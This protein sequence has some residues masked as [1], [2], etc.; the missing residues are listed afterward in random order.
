MKT[1][2]PK[3]AVERK[4]KLGHVEVISSPL[5]K[6][7]CENFEDKEY[8]KNVSKERWE[9]L[10][11]GGK[12]LKIIFSSGSAFK[13]IESIQPPHK[14]IAFVKSALL[15]L[16]HYA[17]AKIDKKSP[18]PFAIRDLMKDSALF[19]STAFPLRHVEVPGKN[20]FH[21]IREIIFESIKDKGLNNSIDG[22][23]M[24]TLKW[25]VYEKWD[26]NSTKSLEEFGCPHCGETEATLAFNEEKGNCP[27]CNNEIF[28]TDLFGLHFAMQDDYAPDQVASDY[29][30]VCE[31]LMI[32]SPIRYFW[33]NNKE[34]LDESLMIKSGALSLRATLSKLKAPI[35]RFFKYAKDAGH[36]VALIGYER[37]GAFFDHFDLIAQDAPEGS[38]FIPDNDYIKQEIQH[39][40]SLGKYGEYTNYGAKVFIKIDKYH[41]L[42][43]NI[44]TGEQYEGILDP[45]QN[46]LIALNKIIATLPKI[47]NN[48]YEGALLPVELVSGIAS[49]STYPSA[50]ALELFSEFSKNKR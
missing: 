18:S 39:T 22:A 28:I 5:V 44:P 38:I 6:K 3:G 13:T 24:E 14:A 15:K 21:A 43:L 19:H 7:L 29:M 16:D 35:Q 4:S 10:P 23:M 42:V 34:H 17:I 46:K 47:L 8:P 1:Q 9:S 33:G 27:K 30:I 26:P 20:L 32:F 41:R 49:L 40:N 25:I 45:S 36:E 31:T 50:K 12:E 37:S 2:R 11:T 48:K